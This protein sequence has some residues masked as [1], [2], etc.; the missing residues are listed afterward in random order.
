VVAAADRTLTMTSRGGKVVLTRAG[1][2]AC[3]RDGF[4]MPAGEIRQL[5][6]AIC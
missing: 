1:S 6:P 4:Q 5:Q 3:Y 2:R